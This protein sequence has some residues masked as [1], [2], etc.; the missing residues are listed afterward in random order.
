[1][2]YK[3]TFYQLLSIT[4]IGMLVILERVRDFVNSRRRVKRSTS[5][6]NVYKYSKRKEIIKKEK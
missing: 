2:D 4:L 6:K 5:S 3:R 1:M